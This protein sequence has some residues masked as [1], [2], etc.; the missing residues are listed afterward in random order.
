MKDS[1]KDLITA[2]LKGI[3]SQI[4]IVG[5]LAT[6]Y[7]EYENSTKI[8][9]MEAFF[10]DLDKKFKSNQEKIDKDYI[11]TDEAAQ[12]L[13]KVVRSISEES[14]IEKRKLLTNYLLNSYSYRF[15]KKTEKLII[16]NAIQVMTP[17]QVFV[18]DLIRDH[19]PPD[20]VIIGSDY[21]PDAS[22]KPIIKYVSEKTIV[23]YFASN[24]GIAAEEIEAT[25]FSM[26]GQGLLE[27]HSTRGWTTV[28]GKMGI[29]G[30]RP[31]KLGLLV[32]EYLKENE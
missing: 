11:K 8:R 4:P 18:L 6:A 17:L 10:T 21:N 32:L 14:D 7:S 26:M 1:Q 3:A 5:G 12:L 29:I 25:L 9:R 31:T 30:Y 27:T 20:N 2:S 15:S 23:E 28:G 16:L 22:D 19:I 13:E 24:N